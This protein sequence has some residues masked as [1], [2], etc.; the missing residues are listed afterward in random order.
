MTDIKIVSPHAESLADGQLVGVGE[1]AHDVDLDD[2]H[3]QRLVK[4]GKA[5]VLE[6][7]SSS[8]ALPPASTVNDEEG[9]E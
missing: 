6:Q 7:Q 5:I 1:V 8:A 4:E 3:N 2:D 9:S